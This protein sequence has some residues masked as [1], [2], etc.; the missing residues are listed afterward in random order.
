MKRTRPGQH[1]RHECAHRLAEHVAERQQIEEANRQE[2][3]RP[4]PVLRDLF[5]DGNDVGEDVPMGD[6]D[7]LWIRGRA[8]RKDD[9]RGIVRRQLG[10]V[11]ARSISRSVMPRSLRSEVRQRPYRAVRA[12]SAAAASTTSPMRIARARDDVGDAQRGMLPMRD[13]RWGRGRRPRGGIPRAPR[14]TPGRFSLQIATACPLTMPAARSRPANRAC[15]GGGVAIAQ[16]PRAIPI[17]VDEKLAVECREIVEEV[18]ERA[19]R[20][21]Q[22]N[23]DLKPHGASA[24][25]RGQRALR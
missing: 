7:A 1:R 16:R 2:R 24:R 13:S 15:R 5:L 14:S 25:V 20:S 23:Y 8:G 3:L 21:C 10:P 4:L 18:D 22:M 6:D 17:V 12:L 19:P 11:R 9:F